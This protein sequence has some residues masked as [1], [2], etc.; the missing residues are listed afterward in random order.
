MLDAIM[1]TGELVLKVLPLAIVLYYGYR[2]A[3]RI[4]RWF[5]EYFFGALDE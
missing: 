2:P 1:E 4:G 5:S 3:I